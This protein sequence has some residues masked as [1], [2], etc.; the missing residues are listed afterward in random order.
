MS[1]FHVWQSHY[2]LYLLKQLLFRSF[3]AWVRI[4]FSQRDDTHERDSIKTICHRCLPSTSFKARR[5]FFTTKN[6]NELIFS[7]LSSSGGC[8]T[9]TEYLV[10]ELFSGLSSFV[11]L[12][13][14]LFVRSLVPSFSVR[15]GNFVSALN[16]DERGWKYSI[17]KRKTEIMK[18][19]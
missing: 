12:S 19:I 5:T 13:V 9:K 1:H 18:T 15:G 14:C 17:W 2:T 4:G 11:C 6:K 8:Q 3:E 16:S 10:F 7:F